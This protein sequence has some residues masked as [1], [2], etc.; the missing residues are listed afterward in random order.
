MPDQQG[1]GQQGQGQGQQIQDTPE[2]R[3]A[4]Y[5]ARAFAGHLTREC[6]TSARAARFAEGAPSQSALD[7][8]KQHLHDLRQARN[9][10]V[11]KYQNYRDLADP[12][13][14]TWVEQRLGDI[15]EQFN[16]AQETLLQG[17]AALN[18]AG[19]GRP[20][21]APAAP[22]GGGAQGGVKV[23][24]A[25]RPSKLHRDSTPV[26]VGDWRRSYRAYHS[27]SRLS[28]LAVPEQQA[29]FMA[30]LDPIV[31]TEIRQRVADDTPVLEDPDISDKSCIQEISIFFKEVYPLFTRRLMFFRLRQSQ[32]QSFAEF[33]AELRRTGD[34]ADLEDLSQDDLMVHRLLAAVRDND[35]REELMKRREPTLAQILQD[36]TAWTMAQRS[37]KAATKSDSNKAAQMTTKGLAPGQCTFC[38]LTP[39]CR[40]GTCRARSSKCHNCNK[41]GHWKEYKGILLCPLLRGGGARPRQ[42]QG[43]GQGQRRFN[44]QR[45]RNMQQPPPE[46]ADRIVCKQATGS[47]PTPPLMVHVADEHG[48]DILKVEAVPDTGTTRS[49]ISAELIKGT[50]ARIRHERL[51]LLNASG[52]RMRTKGVVELLVASPKHGRQV[53]VSAIVS[54]SLGPS[55][56][57]LGWKDLV[58]LGVIPK[59]FPTADASVVKK[60][61]SDDSVATILTDFADVV[62]DGLGSSCG[63]IRGPPMTIH[64]RDDVNVRPLRVLTSR[65]VPLHYAAAAEALIDELL[66]AGVIV[67]IT[68]P[69][70]WI[71]P[72]FFVPKPSGKVRLVTDYKELNKCIARPVHP[73]TAA[74]DI[75]RALVASDALAYG[76]VFASEGAIFLIAAFLSLRIAEPSRAP[77]GAALVPGE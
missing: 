72:A 57:L 43:R 40:Q 76:T 12:S 23:Q 18:G 34:E 48:R 14:F 59:N 35:L 73:F 52:A 67:P 42:G 7:T 17:L 1:Q 49:V 77:S 63:T 10:T 65:P 69:T 13:R 16:I 45:T 70:E 51:E 5:T 30:C 9:D 26:E 29:F 74:A 71:S 54:Q 53:T 19:F 55:E 62:G 11:N 8:L 33:Y 21:P 41:Q 47:A 32:G 6:A 64:L 38:G 31:A 20:P 46:K 37:A 36:A 2:A 56:F 25:L 24:D 3:A 44:Q 75:M 66:Q 15:A 68:Q 61:T 60:M 50:S 22:A 4:L 58:S 27:A 28:Q 39:A